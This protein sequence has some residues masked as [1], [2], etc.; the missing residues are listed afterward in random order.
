MGFHWFRDI[1]YLVLWHYDTDSL[2]TAMESLA[3]S[4][5]KN[6]LQKFLRRSPPWPAIVRSPGR[7][8]SVK[9]QPKAIAAA[10]AEVVNVVI[11]DSRRRHAITDRRL[12]IFGNLVGEPAK[13]V[14][15]TRH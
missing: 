15:E 9:H 10:A 1:L 4:P 3:S 2:A 14:V 6:L 7:S 11:V 5:Q 12:E 8:R 13:T